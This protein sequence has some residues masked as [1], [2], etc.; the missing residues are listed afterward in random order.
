MANFQERDD[1]LPNRAVDRAAARCYTEVAGNMLAEKRGNPC[2][3][4]ILMTGDE[5]SAAA[6]EEL[7]LVQGSCI[8]C[9]AVDTWCKLYTLLW[10]LEH[11]GKQLSGPQLCERLYQSDEGLMRSILVDLSKAGFLVEV[12]QRFELSDDPD[13]AACLNYLHQ[14]FADPQARQR[15]IERIREI[16]PHK[17]ERGHAI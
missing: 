7:R 13:V 12:D 8:R 4:D 9:G 5:S 1:L 14:N 6:T 10:L 17:Q 15:L 2:S 3:K 16:E 11:P